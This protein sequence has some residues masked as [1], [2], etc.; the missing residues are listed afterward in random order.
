MITESQ[1]SVIV[2]NT[3]NWNKLSILKYGTKSK[4]NQW[5]EYTDNNDKY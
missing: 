3:V 5:I 4:L 2:R 1:L